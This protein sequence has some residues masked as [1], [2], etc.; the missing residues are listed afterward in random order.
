M[1]V[2]PTYVVLLSVRVTIYPHSFRQKK[3]K[4][5]FYYTHRVVLARSS[6]GKEK[7]EGKKKKEMGGVGGKYSH[8]CL[9][10]SSASGGSEWTQPS[11][12]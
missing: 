9:A 12:A 11:N 4:I 3:Q 10:G 1:T 7:G 8:A 6:I 5:Y 2:C